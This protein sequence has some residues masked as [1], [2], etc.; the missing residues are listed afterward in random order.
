MHRFYNLNKTIILFIIN[1]NIFFL[2]GNLVRGLLSII[3]SNF[4]YIICIINKKFT[5]YYRQLIILLLLSC[6]FL[7]IK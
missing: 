3:N 2:P 4:N 6:L 5:S 7:Y 1:N